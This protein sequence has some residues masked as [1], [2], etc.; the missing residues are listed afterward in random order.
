MERTC[1]GSFWRFLAR[2]DETLQSVRRYDIADAVWGYNGN[3]HL[4][5]EA[6]DDSAYGGAGDDTGAIS[7]CETSCVRWGPPARI[8]SG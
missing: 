5:G 6:G 4:A 7:C 1:V 2:T 8:K 3:D